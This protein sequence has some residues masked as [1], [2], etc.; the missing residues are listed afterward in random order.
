MNEPS[1]DSEAEKE[2]DPKD[3]Q[4]KQTITR[5]TPKRPIIE[6]VVINPTEGSTPKPKPKEPGV[7]GKGKEKATEQEA[8]PKSTPNTEKDV[9]LARKLEEKERHKASLIRERKQIQA[10]ETRI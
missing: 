10:S 2:S 7:A 3:Q 4:P 9:E 8:N 1:K 6:G 5:S